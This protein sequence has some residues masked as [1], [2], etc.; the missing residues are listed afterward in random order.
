M[1]RGDGTV[2]AGMGPM[3]GCG[4]GFCSG[5]EVPGFQNSSPGQGWGLGS[6]R[7]YRRTLWVTGLIPG[8]VYLAYRWENRNRMK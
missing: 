8:C 2:P 4:T 3:T 1:P 7:G 6:G 5:F